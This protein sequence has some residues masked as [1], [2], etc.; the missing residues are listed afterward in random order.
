[1]NGVFINN[2]DSKGDWIMDLIAGDIVRE[3]NQLGISCRKGGYEDYQGEEI[4][5]HLFWG[6][7][8]PFKNAIHNSIFFTHLNFKQMENYLYSLK[9]DYDSFVCMSPEDAQ[10]LIE[11]GFDKKKVYGRTLPVRNNYLRPISIGMFSAC[12]DD[13]RKN[14]SWIIEYCQNNKNASLVNF[15]FIGPRW[16]RVVN[17]LDSCN[18]SSEWHNIKRRLPFEYQY[19]QN[20]LATLDYYIYLGMDGGAMGTYDAYAQG[21][22]LCVTYDGFHKSIPNIDYKFDNKEG[23]FRQMDLILEKEKSRYDFF[24]ANTPSKYVEWLISVWKGQSRQ[25]ITEQDKE[26][27]SFKNVLEKKRTQY[28][29]L[30]WGRIKLLLTQRYALYKQKKLLLK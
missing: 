29:K 15:V 25:E 30:T 8:K 24:E 17:A 22:K 4:V 3:C 5:Y 28:Y 13:G 18:C 2:L 21:V 26:C 10:F 6:L 27:I 9:D 1:M 16:G 12:Y 7:S 11:L 20:Q 14:E 23:F 19:Q